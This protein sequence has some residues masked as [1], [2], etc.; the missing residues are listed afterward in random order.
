[1]LAEIATPL[2]VSRWLHL[3]AAIVGLGGMWF[4]RGVLLPFGSLE[5]NL[6]QVGRAVLRRWAVTLHACLLVLVVSGIYN[7]ITQLQHHRGQPTYLS[8]WIAKVILALVLFFLAAAV[9]GSNPLLERLRRQRKQWLTL[10]LLLGG[11]IVLLSNML[12]L[13]PPNLPLTGPEM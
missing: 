8:I 7:S 2:V 10:C 4:L 5:T 3:V 6:P 1:M 12:K 11:V 13:T 9:T